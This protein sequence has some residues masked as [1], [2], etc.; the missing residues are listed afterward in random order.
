M[1]PNP[2]HGGTNKVEAAAMDL[3]IYFERLRAL[4]MAKLRS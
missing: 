1:W 2:R 4:S 3:N